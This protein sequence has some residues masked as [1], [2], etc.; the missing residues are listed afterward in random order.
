[1]A[2]LKGSPERRGQAIF[3][4]AELWVVSQFVLAWK[5][6]ELGLKIFIIGSG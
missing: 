1:M 4:W 2:P 3:Q 6:R 5:E